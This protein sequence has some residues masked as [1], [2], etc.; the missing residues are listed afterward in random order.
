MGRHFDFQAAQRLVE[1]RIEEMCNQ[2]GGTRWFMHID[3]MDQKKS[4]LPS[5]WAMLSTPMFK[6]G[7]R[8]VSGLIGSMWHGTKVTQ[9][10][11][12]S[13]FEDMLQGAN[14]QDR[15]IDILSRQTTVTNYL[16]G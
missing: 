15:H 14:M 11:I 10:L 6:T 9:V 8:L 2:S 1:G 4:I 3:K 5:I 16:G 12:R 7:D 13:V